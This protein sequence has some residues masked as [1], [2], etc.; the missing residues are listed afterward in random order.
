MLQTA[1][2]PINIDFFPQKVIWDK[3]ILIIF[4][5]EGTGKLTLI[6]FLISWG[7]LNLFRTISFTITLDKYINNL[8]TFVDCVCYLLCI[9]HSISI[10]LY[11][12]LWLSYI[13]IFI[14]CVSYVILA[15]ADL[16]LK[17]RI[18]RLRDLSFHRFNSGWII[19]FT[20]TKKTL[21]PYN[22]LIW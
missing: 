12:C 11:I 21:P 22:S 3:I 1:F 8:I 7:Y 18:Q 14:I 4:A 5:R 2:F 6:I 17:G 20:S 19:F 15:R 9:T 16:S 13:H 10:F